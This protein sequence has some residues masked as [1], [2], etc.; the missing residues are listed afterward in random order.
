M[1][2]FNGQT[3]ECM[4]AGWEGTHILNLPGSCNQAHSRIWL[5]PIMGVVF[6]GFIYRCKLKDSCLW[7]CR[8]SY[9]TDVHLAEAQHGTGAPNLFPGSR[10]PAAPL[11]VQI[12]RRRQFLSLGLA[13]EPIL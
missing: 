7:R 6:L 2:E 3:A 11:P 9:V 5:R 10:G 4:G 12:D 8:G 13:N 1:L